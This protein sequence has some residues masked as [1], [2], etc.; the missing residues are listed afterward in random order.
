MNDVADGPRV[1]IGRI[2]VLFVCYGNIC[3]SPMAEFVFKDLI[4]SEGLADRFD[5]ASAGT[6]GQHIGDPPDGRAAA[7][8]ERHGMSCEGKRSRR[9]LRSDFLDYDYVVCMDRMNMDYVARMSPG[10]N[11]CEAG[12]L[13][14]Y[15]GG[16]EV[17]D[18]YYTGDFEKAFS[19]ISAGCRALLGHIRE[20]HPELGRWA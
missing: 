6:S 17:A 20:C 7:V 14:G 9:L 19:D 5:V 18:P 13:M 11:A 8:L 4:E 3:R 15:A 2:R 12:M 1:S 16:G 10:S